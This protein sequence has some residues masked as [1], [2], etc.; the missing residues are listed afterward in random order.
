MRNSY[1]FFQFNKFKLN[2][3]ANKYEE[4]INE[5][6]MTSNILSIDEVPMKR[7]ITPAVNNI[8]TLKFP[9]LLSIYYPNCETHHN[10]PYFIIMRLGRS[11]H[12]NDRL[13]THKN[14]VLIKTIKSPLTQ[15]Y[16]KL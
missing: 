8:Q 5:N 9:R 7:K 4:I 1:Y 10:Y 15:G 6:D 2:S 11:S 3:D 14:E 12:D 16:K 13:S